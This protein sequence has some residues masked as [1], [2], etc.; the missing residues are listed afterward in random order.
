MIVSLAHS[1]VQ[2]LRRAY[3]DDNRE[4]LEVEYGGIMMQHLPFDLHEGGRCEVMV[5]EGWLWLLPTAL[6]QVHVARQMS[7]CLLL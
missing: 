5:A 7:V 6:Q 2:R 3:L 4:G 1:H